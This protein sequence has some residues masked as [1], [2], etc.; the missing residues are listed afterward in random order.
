M[1]NA[2]RENI[3]SIE[4]CDKIAKFHL[5]GKTAH[6]CRHTEEFV[7][8]SVLINGSHISFVGGSWEWERNWQ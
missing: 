1:P 7:A 5:Q 4:L 3:A 6:K 8:L 2:V